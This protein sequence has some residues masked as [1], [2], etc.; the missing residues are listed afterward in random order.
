[1]LVH[2]R[3]CKSSAPFC[4]PAQTK[5]KGQGNLD[6]RSWVPLP[7]VANHAPSATDMRSLGPRLPIELL[8]SII[9]CA[10]EITPIF[11]GSAL[12]AAY[13][14]VG[15]MWRARI[16]ARRFRVLCVYIGGHTTAE[17]ELLADI[18]TSKIWPTSDGVA[19]H[20]QVLCMMRG[21]AP[22]DDPAILFERSSARDAAVAG[23]LRSMF[24]DKPRRGCRVPGVLILDPG[25][26]GT[27]K[28]S[29]FDFAT[30]GPGII[31]AMRD[32]LRTA[33]IECLELRVMWGV[34]WSFIASAPIRKLYLMNVGFLPPNAD[35]VGAGASQICVLPELDCI[36]LEYS[37]SFITGLT[38]PMYWPPPPVTTLEITYDT[39]DSNK[40][41]YDVLYHLGGKLQSLHIAID[42]C[43][44]SSSRVN[45]SYCDI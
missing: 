6:I 30:L 41:F 3:W 12:L 29:G 23:V 36:R 24:R 5:R 20:V 11:D 15:R 9:S 19:C 38:S 18:C 43:E 39:G 31:A 26:Y 7:N 16:N 25:R 14:L 45:I 17:L 35:G 42:T 13:A 37:P 40:E 22:M 1:M 28:T 34:P 33:D 21:T 4:V 27:G 10:L 8:D 2:F 32:L 44:E